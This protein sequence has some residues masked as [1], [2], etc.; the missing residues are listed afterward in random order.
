MAVVHFWKGSFRFSRKREWC[1]QQHNSSRQKPTYGWDL[2]VLSLDLERKKTSV[3]HSSHSVSCNWNK[4]IY[5]CVFLP[6]FAVACCVI[7]QLLNWNSERIFAVL[8][9]VFV[10]LKTR[11]L[12]RSEVNWLVVLLP[13]LPSLLVI[14]TSPCSRKWSTWTTTR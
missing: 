13:S 4:R 11:G 3:C 6:R 5:F 10:V 9:I 14:I 1:E 8:Y 7:Y 2:L 12:L